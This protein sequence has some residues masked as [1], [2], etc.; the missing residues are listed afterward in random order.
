MKDIKTIKMRYVLAGLL[1]LICS[2]LIFGAS[3]DYLLVDNL[4]SGLGITLT[5]LV[6]ITIFSVFV[7]RGYIENKL[8]AKAVCVLFTIQNL[9][10]VVE[11]IKLVL[12]ISSWYMLYVIIAS[13]ISIIVIYVCTQV[14]YKNKYTLL[15]LLAWLTLLND[16]LIGNI[17]GVADPNNFALSCFII[18]LKVILLIACLYLISNS[19][20]KYFKNF[21]FKSAFNKKVEIKF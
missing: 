21:S 14:L 10:Y 17:S 15:P 5:F 8:F 6:C 13:I 2:Y 9:Y 12:A 3:K 18:S 1:I 19:L 16:R 11:H 20:T 7:A 4:F